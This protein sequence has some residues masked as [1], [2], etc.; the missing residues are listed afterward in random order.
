MLS[1]FIAWGKE[2]EVSLFH[3]FFIGLAAE[4]LS[5]TLVT[6][7]HPL[8]FP[9]CNRLNEGEYGKNLEHT[10]RAEFANTSLLFLPD[11]HQMRRLSYSSSRRE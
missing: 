9:E 2:Q 1:H 5:S 7:Q 8:S 3:E 6:G 11:Q 10:F 4:S